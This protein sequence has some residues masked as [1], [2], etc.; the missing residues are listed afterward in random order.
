MQ[1]HDG[2]VFQIIGD[3]FCVAFHTATDALLAELRTSVNEIKSHTCGTRAG[4]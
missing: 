2:Y 3:A 1:A 4:R